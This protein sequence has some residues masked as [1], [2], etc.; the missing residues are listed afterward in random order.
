MAHMDALINKKNIS[1]LLVL[2]EEGGTFQD[3]MGQKDEDGYYAEYC[4]F[5]STLEHKYTSLKT[6][7]TKC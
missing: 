7:L 5:F 6:N 4:H 1:A 3:H 2:E